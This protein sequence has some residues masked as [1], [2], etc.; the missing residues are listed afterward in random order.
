[1]SEVIILE[2]ADGTADQYSAVNKVLGINLATGE[3][4]WPAGLQ[5]HTGAFGDAGLVVV[6]VWES[7]DAQAAFMGRLGPAL[8]EVGVPQP[9]RTEW[10]SLLGRYNA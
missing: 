10:L 8:A 6:E 1:M 5:S 4:D 3:G 9:T 7:Q 2:F